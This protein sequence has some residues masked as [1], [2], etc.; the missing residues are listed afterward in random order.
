MKSLIDLVTIRDNLEDMRHAAVQASKWEN[1]R[2]L[3]SAV[4]ALNEHIQALNVRPCEVA[5]RDRLPTTVDVDV[6]GRQPGS[7]DIPGVNI[8]P[9][10]AP[11]DH[12]GR[13]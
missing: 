8:V 10:F 13:D 1:A 6:A 3:R 9:F 12:E 4:E 5:H 7:P 2:N 11:F